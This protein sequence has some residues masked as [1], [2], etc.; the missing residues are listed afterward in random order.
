MLLALALTQAQVHTD[1]M[2]FAMPRHREHRMQQPTL[3]GA[4]DADVEVFVPNDREFRQQRI[5]MVAIRVHRIAAIGKHRPH[6]VGQKFILG[7]VRPVVIALA[8]RAMH[9]KHFLQEH[10]I[11]AQRPHSL[12]QLGQH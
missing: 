11:G 3:L 6:A 12:A 5:A 1:G 10:H 7:D 9:P 4:V 8:V 2:H